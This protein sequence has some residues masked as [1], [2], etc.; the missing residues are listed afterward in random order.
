MRKI[1]SKIFLCVFLVALGAAQAVSAKERRV[2]LLIGNSEYEHVSRLENPANDAE[3]LGNA[4]KR[5]GFEVTSGLDMEYRDMRLALR[6]FSDKAADAEM[7]LIYFAG[8]GIEIDKVNYLIPVNAEL[9]SDRDI[10]FEAIRLDTVIGSLDDAKGVRIVLLDACRNNPFV[11]GMQRT[12]ATRS[13]GRGLS[14][15]DPGGV[16]V[17]YAARGGTIALDGDGRNSP[18]AQAILAN[19]EEPGLEVGKLFRRVRDMVLEQTDGLQEP[20]TYGSLPGDD[21]FLVPPV[22]IAAAASP[23]PVTPS[24]NLDA[25][26]ED[27]AQAEEHDTLTRWSGFVSQYGDMEE[28]RLVQIA[29]RRQAELQKEK[30]RLARS[31]ARPPIF[32]PE[33]DKNGHAILTREQSKLLQQALAYMGHY[34]GPIDG[35]IGP[36]SRRAITSARLAAKLALGAHVDRPLLA[37]LPDVA[38]INSLIPQKARFIDA[39][40]LP[41][42]LEPR[43]ERVL[44]YFDSPYG[45]SKILFDYFQGNLYIVVSEDFGGFGTAVRKAG[46]VGGHLVSIQSAAENQFLVDLFSKDPR[47]IW[48]DGRGSL[49]GPMIG[50]F[51][52]P[53]SGE[54]RGG[55]TWVTGEPLNFTAWSPGNPDNYQ[56]RQHRARFYL[57]GRMVGS[58]SKPRFWDDTSNHMMNL[59][60]IIEVE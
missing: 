49:Y 17:G 48:K 24:S 30:E 60:F 44:K 8:H 6:D 33:F 45:R 50:L 11:A 47:F 3:D 5:L 35:D 59:G 20:F 12:T 4:L 2:A 36:Q 7:A 53:G 14:R 28:N 40:D 25:M 31:A 9:E 38:A 56:N 57:N 51:Q 41:V 26:L 18:Y 16:L 1:L 21:I 15:I 37:A 55:W 23:A 54:P 52:Q 29:L 43:L 39:E 32:T 42:G 13:I 19:I 58:G 34:N 46:A 10:D 22:E 27:F